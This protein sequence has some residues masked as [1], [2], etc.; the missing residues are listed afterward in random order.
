[1]SCVWSKH[2]KK[3]SACSVIISHAG[4][5]KNLSLIS[6]ISCMC[7]ALAT[8][9]RFCLASDKLDPEFIRKPHPKSILAFSK[10]AGLGE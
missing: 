8:L 9:G 10:A 5:G 2:A 4:L 3:A 1:M 7:D 6:H